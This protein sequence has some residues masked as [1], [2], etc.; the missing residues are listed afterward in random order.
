MGRYATRG[1][2]ARFRGRHLG[3]AVVANNVMWGMEANISSSGV[4]IANNTIAGGNT[5]PSQAT[6]YGIITSGGSTVVNNIVAFN[7]NGIFALDLITAHHNFVVGN[8][9]N[10]TCFS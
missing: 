8:G 7:G 5:G 6:T 2:R 9:G 1:N 4:L 10:Y 3:G